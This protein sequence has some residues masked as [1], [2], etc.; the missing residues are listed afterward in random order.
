MYYERKIIVLFLSN[1]SIT[2]QSIGTFRH[3]SPP[4][5]VEG[6]FRGTRFGIKWLA[7]KL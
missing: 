7:D 2:L 3:K 1:I 6:A 5:L 4:I